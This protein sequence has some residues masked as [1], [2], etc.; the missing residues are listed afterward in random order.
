[1]TFEAS[2]NCFSSS[3]NLSAAIPLPKYATQAVQV[4]FEY[5]PPDATCNP[6][7]AIAA[8]LMAGIDGIRKKIDPIEASFGPFDE[9]VFS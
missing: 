2:V 7:L 1:M 6:Y 8:I 3:G 9:D 4:R 5:R